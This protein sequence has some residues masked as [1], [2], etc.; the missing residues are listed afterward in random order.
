ML[1]HFLLRALLSAIGVA[2]VAGPLGCLVVWRRMAYF[3]DTMAHAALLGVVLGLL[4]E[5]DLMLAVLCVTAG[6]ALALAW[7]QKQR[8]LANDA[9]LGILAHGAL[10]TGLVLITY[11]RGS[12]IDISG[13][14]FGDILSVSWHDVALIYVSAV[15]VLLL[16]VKYWHSLIAMVVSEE[17]AAAEGLHPHR[18]QW[19]MMLLIALFIA[20]A[21]K[22][23]GVLLITALLIIPPAGARRFAADPESMALIA[24]TLGCAAVILGLKGSWWLDTP[25]GPS[26]VLA[27]MLLFALTLLKTSK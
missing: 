14:L 11:I 7:L 22:I 2:I 13:Y 18:M 9:I 23:S 4:F 16:V 24:I 19:L 25:T 8:I 6:S 17:L 27:A 21:M 1:D 20:I 3:G 5:T 12:S 15:V 26:I 10:A